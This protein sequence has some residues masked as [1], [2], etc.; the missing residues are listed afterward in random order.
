VIKKTKMG[1]ARKFSP[2]TKNHNIAYI[3][4]TGS[5]PHDGEPVVRL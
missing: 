5:S 4:T 1:L 2:Y 3:K